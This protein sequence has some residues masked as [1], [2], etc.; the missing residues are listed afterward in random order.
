MRYIGLKTANGQE[1]R[2]PKLITGI[3]R[4]ERDEKYWVWIGGTCLGEIDV[5]TWIRL[6]DE[7]KVSRKTSKAVA[8]RKDIRKWKKR[9]A[10]DFTLRPAKPIKATPKMAK[11]FE[12]IDPRGVPGAPEY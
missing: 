3:N 12:E 8:W 7:F 1:W 9:R 2:G 5:E 6:A 10:Q 11:H 4:D